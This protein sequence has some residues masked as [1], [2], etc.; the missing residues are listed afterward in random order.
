MLADPG[1]DVVWAQVELGRADRKVISKL[2][3]GASHVLLKSPLRAEIARDILEW[4]EER[5]V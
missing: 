2:Y 1:L 4:I 3:S 5:V